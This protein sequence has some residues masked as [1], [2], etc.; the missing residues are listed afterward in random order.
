MSLT[1]L[2]NKY[3]IVYKI[4]SRQVLAPYEVGFAVFSVYSS[5]IS[6]LNFGVVPN[7]F[8]DAMGVIFTTLSS[9]LFLLSGI[10]IYAGI[11]L[12]KRE[13]EAFGIIVLMS[14]M[15][16]RVVVI[17]ILFGIDPVTFNTAVFNGIFMVS[18]CVRLNTLL[19]KHVIIMLSDNPQDIKIEYEKPNS[20]A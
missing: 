2:F 17:L 7:K 3:G 5:I 4:Y 6:M 18:S 11:S 8:T 14:C 10:A 15:L 9:I 12:S 20:A 1:L 19:K 13:I 16:M